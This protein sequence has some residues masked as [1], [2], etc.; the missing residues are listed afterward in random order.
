MSPIDRDAPARFPLNPDWQNLDPHAGMMV[1]TWWRREK[2]R[3]RTLAIER[4][5][6]DP[7]Y[8]SGQRV[9]L[10]GVDEWLDVAWLH[11]E[12]AEAP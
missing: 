7:T 8:T 2:H 9:E 3:P 10:E 12:N 4:V 5:V 11:P 1:K 6:D